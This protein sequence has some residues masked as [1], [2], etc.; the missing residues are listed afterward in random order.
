M[1]R[2]FCTLFDSNYVFKAVAMHESLARHHDDFRLTAF[3]FDDRAQA[4][5]DRLE[6]R[7]VETVSLP[8]LETFDKELLSTKGDRTPVEYCWTATPALP[9][10]VFDRHP[11]VDEVTYL[12]A[13]LLFYS[14]PE[15]LFEEMGDAAV[16]ITPHRY[17]SE[18]ESEEINGVYNVSWLTF[19]RDPDGLE[20]LQWWHDRCIEWCYFRY[21]DGKLGD[22]K[23]LD[24]WPERFRRVHEMENPGGGLAPWNVTRYDLRGGGEEVTVDGTPLVFFH[25]HGYR[26]SSQGPPRLGP[27][28]YHLSRSTRRLVYEP[29]DRALRR[30]IQRV[31]DLE[32]GFSAGLE[33]RA[34]PRQR[35]RDY[36]VRCRAGL[37]SSR[38]SRA[39]RRAGAR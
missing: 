1:H 13:D 30:A 37:I 23:Y 17:A 32:P 39:R 16:M 36:V 33:P 19:R 11:E 21:E 26:L 2:E 22:Q 38:A 12:D 6:L 27:P 7:G 18:H 3:C 10:F 20:A 8:E 14:D 29:Y 25:Y 34:H 15:A 4:L 5:I 9:L 24:D 28:A 31:R 35:L